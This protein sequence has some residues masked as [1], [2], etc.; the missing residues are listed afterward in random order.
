MALDILQ[1]TPLSMVRYLDRK[2]YEEF[3]KDAEKK[4]REENIALSSVYSGVVES[5]G[6][7]KIPV[8]LITLGEAPYRSQ[9]D[10]LKNVGFRTAKDGIMME[11]V[12]SMAENT[13]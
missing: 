6:Y 9:L 8:I 1:E 4:L 3:E 10:V 5:V 13:E 2:E 11:N 12:Y 7:M